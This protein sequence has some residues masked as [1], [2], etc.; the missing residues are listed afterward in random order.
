MPFPDL[1]I[2][3]PLI[4]FSLVIGPNSGH[5]RHLL[6][7]RSEVGSRCH[8]GPQRCGVSQSPVWAGEEGLLWWT[9]RPTGP[10]HSMPGRSS[11]EGSSQGPCPHSLGLSGLPS[12][13]TPTLGTGDIDHQIRQA[14]CPPG[15]AAVGQ[16]P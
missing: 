6:M 13:P 16:L 3:S 11:M 12:S 7:L 2:L 9:L 1:L 4:N 8:Q 5:P 14:K 10:G 15:P